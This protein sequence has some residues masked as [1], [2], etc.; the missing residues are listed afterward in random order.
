MLTPWKVGFRL[1]LFFHAW[2]FSFFVI[3]ISLKYW[4]DIYW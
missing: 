2:F 3:A 1:E 4:Y